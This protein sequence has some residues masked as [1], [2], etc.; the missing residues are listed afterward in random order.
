MSAVL[1]GKVIYDSVN[2]NESNLSPGTFNLLKRLPK[3]FPF[4]PPKASTYAE[5]KNELLFSSNS[6][7]KV[8]FIDVEKSLRQALDKAGYAE[9]SYF[10]I[11]AGFA[12]VTRLEQINADGTPKSKEIRW[13]PIASKPRV[14]SMTDYLKPLVSG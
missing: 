8:T 9:I 5:I 10:L 7:Q 4:P 6:R 13:L 1:M 12:L 14:F 11:P 2:E 3:I